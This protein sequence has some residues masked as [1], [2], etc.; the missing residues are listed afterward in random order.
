MPP[1]HGDRLVDGGALGVAG[2]VDIARRIGA[3][4]LPLDEVK[5][6]AHA[7]SVKLNDVFLYVIAR[8]LRDVL[9]KRGE[10]VDGVQRSQPSAPPGPPE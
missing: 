2:L 3:I 5:R 1:Q 6:V 7:Q 4:R 8:G 10:P 9:L